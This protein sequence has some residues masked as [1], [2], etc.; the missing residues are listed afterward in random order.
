MNYIQICL[1]AT[2]VLFQLHCH[3]IQIPFY[4]G[5]DGACYVNSCFVKDNVVSNC[6]S[7]CWEIKHQKCDESITEIKKFRNVIYSNFKENESCEK[8][9]I[10][11]TDS[12]FL[13]KTP[14]EEKLFNNLNKK[15]NEPSEPGKKY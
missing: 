4:T 7:S 11:K 15:I 8:K 5:P 10:K 12:D 9:L 14:E 13:Y 6:I 1:S 3:S 2:L